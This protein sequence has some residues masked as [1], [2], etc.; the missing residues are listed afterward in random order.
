ME[1]TMGRVLTRAIVENLGD[2]VEVDCGWRSDQDVRRVTI[3]DALVDTGA[4]TLALPTRIVQQLGLKKVFE[5]QVKST[6]GVGPVSVY[7]AVRLT[8]DGR[9]AAKH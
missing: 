9:E 5:K 4:T 6:R 8:I 3:D 2:L 7:R 1:T